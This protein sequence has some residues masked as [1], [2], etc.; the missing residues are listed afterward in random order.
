MLRRAQRNGRD[1]YRGESI[2]LAQDSGAHQRW[3]FA[4]TAYMRVLSLGWMVQGLLEWWKILAPGK[5]SLD[6]LPMSLAVAIVFFAVADLLA[7]VGLW[8]ATA[9]GGVLWLFSA[10]A[11]IIV[12]LFMPGFRFDGTV[13][14]TVNLLLIVIYFVL[15]W[16]AAL[17]R[18]T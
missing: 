16:Q 4:L 5:I 1:D 17:E 18:D 12:S 2:N 11:A 10:C 7:A 3:N 8:M 15:T 14:L 6:A 9:W 13:A